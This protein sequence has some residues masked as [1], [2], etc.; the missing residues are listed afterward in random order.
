MEEEGK[1]RGEKEESG[2]SNVSI[3]VYHICM[4]V[5]TGTGSLV[6]IRSVK[7]ELTHKLLAHRS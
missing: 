3:S 7:E 1:E 5:G 6:L 2:G 4:M